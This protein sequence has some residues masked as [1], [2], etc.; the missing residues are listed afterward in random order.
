MRHSSPPPRKLVLSL[1]LFTLVGPL[2][3]DMYLPAF[4]AI[5][6][7]LA[8][9]PAMVKYSLVSYVVALSLGQAVWGPVAD[10]VGRRVPLIVGLLLCT[11]ACFCASLAPSIEV[12][13]ALRFL[14][15][16]GAC[17]AVVVARSIARDTGSGERLARLIATMAVIQGISP[18]FGPLLGS[19]V[20]SVASWSAIFLLTGALAGTALA[21]ALFML[22]ETL[23]RARRASG[24]GQALA[25]YRELLIDR[26]FVL[27]AMTGGCATGVFFTY[28][29][30]SPYVLITL[31]GLSPEAYGL[32]FGLNA[33]LM[34][35]GAQ[36]GARLIGRLA[37]SR[38][39]LGAIGASTITILTLL[40]VA[41][42]DQARLTIVLSLLLIGLGFQGIIQ[43]ILVMRALMNYPHA[44]ATTAALMGTIQ[45][46]FGALASAAVGLAADGTVPMAGL[47]AI[48]SASA[49]VLF[50]LSDR[51]A[52]RAKMTGSKTVTRVL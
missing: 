17:A 28:L 24:L 13:I 22:P 14:Q 11:G 3:I 31:G 47:M 45:Y 42:L 23:P 1:G 36:L 10:W 49:G 18:L 21:V 25:R 4:P 38:V 29:A 15:G 2:G 7:A 37:P 8:T 19:L 35:A 9:D 20:L 12:L 30:G 5:A 26:H 50:Y 6:N 52:R 40:V 27:V 48:F 41:V 34:I 33:A 32:F 16:F 39:A 46:A 44:A 51:A 43:P